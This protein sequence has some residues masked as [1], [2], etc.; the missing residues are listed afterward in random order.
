GVGRVRHA[1]ADDLVAFG[2]IIRVA[3]GLNPAFEVFAVEE[4]NPAIGIGFLI[5]GEDGEASGGKRQQTE[6]QL[7]FHGRWSGDDYRLNDL[8]KSS[9]AFATTF[10]SCFELAMSSF[11]FFSHAALS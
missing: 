7:L 5:G 1:G 4:R 9:A 6:S 11:S 2:A 3:T 8:V 10:F